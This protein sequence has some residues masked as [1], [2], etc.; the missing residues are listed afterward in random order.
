M[1]NI[2]FY[3]KSFFKNLLKLAIKIFSIFPLNEKK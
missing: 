1:R 2:N 3:I